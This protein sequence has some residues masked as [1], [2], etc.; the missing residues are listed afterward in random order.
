MYTEVEALL[1]VVVRKVSW[2]RKDLKILL[3]DGWCLGKRT[4]L[5]NRGKHKLSEYT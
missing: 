3:K 2:R 4:F 1:V 5:D